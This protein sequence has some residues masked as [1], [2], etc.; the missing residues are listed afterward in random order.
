M[1]MTEKISFD[2]M[3]SLLATIV[4]KLEA[5]EEKVDRLN[6]SQQCEEKDEWFNLK[7]LC[8]YLPSR[9]AEQTVYG[10]TS[11]NFIPFHKKGKSIAFRKSEIDQWLQQSHRKSKSDL[12]LEASQF[13]N[14]KRIK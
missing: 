6:L 9:P 4:Q 13:V 10:W 3:P 14:K 11:T 2:A 1:Y 5:L 12:M 8:K 7:E